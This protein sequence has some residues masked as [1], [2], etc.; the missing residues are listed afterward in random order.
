MNIFFDLVFKSCCFVSE[1]LLSPMLFHFSDFISSYSRCVIWFKEKRYHLCWRM[2]LCCGIGVEEMRYMCWMYSEW[3][4]SRRICCL[5]GNVPTGTQVLF[6]RPDR[7]KRLS[8]QHRN[9]WKIYLGF[10]S[11]PSA[12]PTHRLLDSLKSPRLA[13]LHRKSPCVRMRKRPAEPSSPMYH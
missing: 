3:A 2:S 10:S 8:V 13:P 9:L 5:R 7:G 4:A 11:F 12:R 6:G 1:P